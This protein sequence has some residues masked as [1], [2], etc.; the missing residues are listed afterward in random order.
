MDNGM[1]YLAGNSTQY[2]DILRHYFFLDKIP[3]KSKKGQT[4]INQTLNRFA[5]KKLERCF[6]R[7][8]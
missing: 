5:G 8:T 7:I 4:G 1:V 6:I 3:Y 2:F